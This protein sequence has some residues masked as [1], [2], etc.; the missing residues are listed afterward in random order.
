MIVHIHLKQ[1]KKRGGHVAA[2]PYELDPVP[3]TLRQ[4]ITQLVT[5]G[6]QGYN[7]RVA[8]KDST[9][10]LSKEDMEAMEAIGKIGF[11]IPYGSR[12]ADF[13]E[14]IDATLQGY[15]DSLFR[16]F[17]G[18]RETESLDAPLNLRENDTITIIRLVMLTGGYF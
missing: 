5:D 16:I 17:I 2:C 4:L 1:I 8:Q 15:E 18:D 13:A 11:G 14:A 7:A 3:E 12:E 10:L 9:V 6:V